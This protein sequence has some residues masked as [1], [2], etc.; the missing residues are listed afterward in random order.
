[1]I[2]IPTAYNYQVVDAILGYLPNGRTKA[3]VVGVQITITDNR[4]TSEGIFMRT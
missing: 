2:F 4:S 1:M 3:I